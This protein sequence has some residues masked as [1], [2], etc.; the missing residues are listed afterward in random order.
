MGSSR[1]EAKGRVKMG[2]NKQQSAGHRLSS[3]RQKER[4]KCDD[5]RQQQIVLSASECATK[6]LQGNNVE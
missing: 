2:R 3:E 1:T 4:I 6:A 5:T